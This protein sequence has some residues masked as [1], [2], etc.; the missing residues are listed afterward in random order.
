MALRILLHAIDTAAN[1]YK[2]YIVPW[3]SLS[4]DFYI[5]VFV[6]VLESPAEVKKSSLK[7]IMVHQSTLC[8]SFYVNKLSI[9][10]HNGN[11]T[12][13]FATAPN[14]CPETQGN[15]KV[16]GPFWGDIIHSQ[17]IVDELIKALDEVEYSKTT[18]SS[19]TND[20]IKDMA[21]G[22]TYPALTPTQPSTIT[23]IRGVLTSVQE[24]LKDVPF[25]YH[26]PELASTVKVACPS[27]IEMRS[28][29]MNAGY[30]V[31]QFHHD[32]DAIKTD[33]PAQFVS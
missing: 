12:S 17:A 7:R 2:R 24:E 16:G 28:A 1:K 26:L 14:V 27:A 13:A 22:V 30:R 11:I 8:P 29:I 18:T 25:Y 33:A 23:R 20:N 15:I 32:P 9:R 3:V 21:G 19:S 5:R 31:S 4:V 10:K 6:R